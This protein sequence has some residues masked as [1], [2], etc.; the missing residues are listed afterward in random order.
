MRLADVRYDDGEMRY[1]QHH[2][3]AP[4]EAL[5]GYLEAARELL[6]NVP[7]DLLETATAIPL[8]E[9]FEQLRWFEL[10]PCC[11]AAAPRNYAR[12]SQMASRHTGDCARTCCYLDV[13]AIRPARAT[14]PSRQS[15]H[16]DAGT[17]SAPPGCLP[18][19][20]KRASL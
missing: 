7:P 8:S 20:E 4:E 19:P 2:D 18:I 6:R 1:P 17:R 15:A 12:L 3:R 16:A 13:R 10:P 5:Q 9:G 11:L 14:P